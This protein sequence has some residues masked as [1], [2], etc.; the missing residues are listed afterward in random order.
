MATPHA[1]DHGD[2]LLA[3]A[4]A[5]HKAE[6][7]PVFLARAAIGL[8]SVVVASVTPSGAGSVAIVSAAEASAL[9]RRRGDTRGAARVAGTPSPGFA[10]CVGLADATHTVSRLAMTPILTGGG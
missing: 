5:H 2:P 3:E 9:L 6:W 8:A 1:S 10:W 7:V 4:I